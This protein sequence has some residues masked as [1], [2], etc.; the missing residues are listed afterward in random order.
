MPGWENQYEGSPNIKPATMPGWENR[1]KGSPDR[2]PVAKPGCENQHKGSPTIVNPAEH[3]HSLV[4]LYGQRTTPKHQKGDMPKEG[5]ERKE[6]V[7]LINTPTTR[8]D[9]CLKSGHAIFIPLRTYGNYE[10]DGFE[11]ID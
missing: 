2:Q 7:Q 10:D 4:T 6:A 11:I 9:S 8:N 3:A 1:H 5:K